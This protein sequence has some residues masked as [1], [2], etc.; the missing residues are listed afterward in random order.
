MQSFTRVFG[1]AK[2]EEQEHNKNYEQ[3]HH[4]NGNSRIRKQ[5]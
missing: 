1:A 5:K 2:K 4:F 3:E